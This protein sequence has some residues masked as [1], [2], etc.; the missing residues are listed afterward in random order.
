MR[1]LG[2]KKRLRSGRTGV[3][4]RLETAGFQH[5]VEVR[6]LHR[7]CG[8]RSNLVDNRLRRSCGRKHTSGKL[9]AQPGQGLDRRGNVGRGL[10]PCRRADRENANL[11]GAVKS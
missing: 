1:A 7:L 11:A 8:R 5:A 9:H 3:G 2:D 6:I 4:S 10:E